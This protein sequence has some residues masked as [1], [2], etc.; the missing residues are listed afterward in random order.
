MLLTLRPPRRSQAAARQYDFEVR[1]AAQDDPASAPA[2]VRLGHGR[3]QRQR[4]RVARP[5][6]EPPDRPELDDLADKVREVLADR[7]PA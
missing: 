4:I 2:R 6:V 1:V 7:Q 5:V 3:Q